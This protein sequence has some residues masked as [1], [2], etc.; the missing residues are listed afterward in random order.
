MTC[1]ITFITNMRKAGVDHS[2]I[3]KL[4]SHKTA[5]MFLR[6]NSADFEDARGAYRKLEELLGKGQYWGG[7]LAEMCSPGAPKGG[8]CQL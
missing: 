7:T 3:M 6:Y 5:T 2:V 1:A 8:S 4:T